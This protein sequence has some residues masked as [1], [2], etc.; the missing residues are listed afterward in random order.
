MADRQEWQFVVTDALEKVF[1]DEAPAERGGGG[2][3]SVFLGETASF[4]LAF[5]PPVARKLQNLDILR[6]EVDPAS[7]HLVTM[8]TVD[9]VP[10]MLV[11]FEGHDDG[12]LRDKPGLY[13]DLLTPCPDGIV[14]PSIGL[15]RS[16]WFDVRADD[17]ADSGMHRIGITVRSARDDRILFTTGIDVTVIPRTLPELDIVN[18]HWLHADCLAQ[19][20]DVEVFSEEHWRIIEQFVMSAAEMNATSL[21]TPTWTPPLD[22]KVGGRRLPVQLIDIAEEHGAY[23]FEFGK[24]RRWLD[25]CARHGIRTVEIAHLFTQWGAEATPAIYVDTPMGVEQR[26]GWHVPAVAPEYRDLLEQLIPA[27]RAFLEESWDGAVVYHVSDEPRGFMIDSY[28]AAR[29]VVDD[30]L[31]GCLIID[32]LSDLEFAASGVVD[33]PVVATNAVRPFLEAGVDPLWVY[34]CVSQ[35]TDVANRYIG[36]PSSRSRVLG[37][38]LF[39]FR[40]KGFL[41]WGFNFYNAQYSTHPI[42]PF[43]DT[44]ANG[45]FPAGDPFIVYPGPDGAPLLSIR[46]RVFA[47]AM[48]DHRAMQLLRDLRGFDAVIAVIDPGGTLAFDSFSYDPLHYLRARERINSEIVAAL[49]EA[50]VDGEMSNR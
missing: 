5:L 30:L 18:T 17:L 8:S 19:Y 43:R 47:Q 38:Q 39:A 28:A 40:V 11:A 27:L 25:I 48:A 2:A 13:P 44:C 32:A 29:A 1:P 42:D 37:H 31:E 20:Y 9:L 26:F 46:Y 21:L 35:H 22:T 36:L 7:A 33:V 10:A 24:L 23:R 6:I 3:S 41:H 50:K 14:H 15:W 16:V 12:Y 45:A 34:Y 4:Q 49:D